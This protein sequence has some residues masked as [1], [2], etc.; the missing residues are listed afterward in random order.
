MRNIK[1]LMDVLRKNTEMKLPKKGSEAKMYR[2]IGIIALCC[3]MI[4]CCLVVGYVSY[5]MTLAL[6][7][8][9]NAT[10][11]IMAEVHIMSAFSL[12]FGMLVIFNI[13]FF[14]SD[15]EHLMPLPFKGYEMLTAKFFY[16]YMAESVME[17]LIL[18]SIF[19]GYFIAVGISFGGILAAIVGVVIIPLMP[20]AYCAIISLIL[21]RVLRNVKNSRV[22]GHSSTV[23]LL[24][25]IALFMLSFR[26]MGGITVDN[27]VNSLASGDNLFSDTLSRI[28]F[29]VP[30]LMNALNCSNPI[31]ISLLNLLA[32]IGLNVL[33][34]VVM[35]VFGAYTYTDSLQAVGAMGGGRHR[36]NTNTYAG[37]QKGVWRSYLG[38]EV[39]VLLRTK[40]YSGNCVFINLLWP[41]VLIGYLLINRDKAGV[42]KLTNYLAMG[43]QRAYVLLTIAVVLL[44]FL[45]S[46][47]N[48]LAS[49]A[50]TR[51]GQHVEMLKYIPVS[52]KTQAMIKGA[53]S[54]LITYPPLLLCDIALAVFFRISLGMFI[55]YAV[56]MLASLVITSVLGMY[57]DSSHPHVTWEDEYSALRGNLNT[58]FDMA[59]VMVIAALI[60]GSGFAIYHFLLIGLGGF[61]LY[62]AAVVFIGM[63]VLL[64]TLGRRI[65]DNMECM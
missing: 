18:I 5:V 37:K 8:A 38:K 24:A 12:I 55:Y 39:K 2:V 58:F 28:F 17:F 32:C 63:I 7:E 27:Y 3:I 19:A 59:I 40:A 57:L 1:A 20:L 15:R 11:G 52:Y 6:R 21:L 41:V 4:P 35:I 30:F 64:V 44:A 10:A 56:V 60:L 26:G 31:G 14:S 29:S 33:V 25:F 34:V 45:S 53:V 54:I 16:A 23:F 61:L 9:G 62:I 36:S 50:F 46:A 47:M 49:T 22:F 51:E 43:Y 48:S 13:L 42:I 65:P